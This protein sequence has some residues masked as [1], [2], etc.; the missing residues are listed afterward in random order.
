MSDDSLTIFEELE[1]LDSIPNS[2]KETFIYIAGYVAFTTEAESS[3]DTFIYYESF[4]K[5]TNELSRC[6]LRI[7]Y[8]T[9]CQFT[10][11]EYVLLLEEK[12]QVCRKSLVNVLK[13]LTVYYHF[14]INKRCVIVLSNIYLNNYTHL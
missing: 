6:K 8:D 7:P 12:T 2:V 10:F 4:C 3:E 1:I 11:F 5:F 14:E 9:M 13:C